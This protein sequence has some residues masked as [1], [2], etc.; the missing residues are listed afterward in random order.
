M[1][2]RKHFG[3]G[4]WRTKLSRLSTAGKRTTLLMVPLL[5]LLSLLVAAI[6][7]PKVSAA[8]PTL[9]WIDNQTVQV[10]GGDVKGTG[11]VTNGNCE[12][13]SGLVFCGS[14]DITSTKGCTV[15]LTIGVGEGE[16]GKPADYSK[17]YIWTRGG[18][19][20]TPCKAAAD[21]DLG[22]FESGSTKL[23][24]ITN[25]AARS[26]EGE[27][28]VPEQEDDPE[29]KQIVE[30]SM[31]P[32]WNSTY[33]VANP[34]SP[35][36]AS[37]MIPA[38]D[39][40]VLCGNA[41]DPKTSYEDYAKNAGQ[42]PNY[43]QMEEDCLNRKSGWVI[44]SKR[45]A[46]TSGGSI[47][48]ANKFTGVAAGNY[49][50]CD[51]IANDCIAFQKTA[52]EIKKINWD[53]GNP[54]ANVPDASTDADSAENEPELACDLAFDLTT[55]FSVKWLVCPI[56]NGAT[57][58]VGIMEDIINSLLT[59]DVQDIFDDKDAS[60]A[61]HKAW[62]SFR[63]F[64]LGLIVIAALVMVVSQAAGVEILDAYTV[65]KVLP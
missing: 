49:V 34:S 42:V 21:M 54:K 58:L 41:A 1:I 63:I 64:A 55:I 29:D 5:T 47:K 38:E 19:S 33:T 30:V 10:S 27:P 26:N 13:S 9:K 20:G 25:V 62:N 23:Y 15:E 17:A 45:A 4:A 18:E 61:Y 24:T 57:S 31:T 53:E 11:K 65:R 51:F 7:A 16:N 40:W 56:V 36:K 59:V 8:V 35:P 46:Y 48:Y 2:T 22:G 14:A 50:V 12:G 28:E 43:G 44:D 52:G 6:P 3:R 39:L 32:G 60:N 37:E